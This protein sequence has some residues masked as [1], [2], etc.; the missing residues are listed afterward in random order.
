MI[1]R[2]LRADFARTKEN[3]PHMSDNF[4]NAKISKE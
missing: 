3:I 4:L 1:D 2:Y